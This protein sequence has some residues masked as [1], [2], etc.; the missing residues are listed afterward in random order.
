MN[1]FDVQLEFYLN[2]LE[3]LISHPDSPSIKM[4]Y[5]HKEMAFRY[6]VREYAQEMEQRITENVLKAISIKFESGDALNEIKALKNAID[7]LGK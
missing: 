6:A 3:R 5:A 1:R 2:A 7:S 4:D